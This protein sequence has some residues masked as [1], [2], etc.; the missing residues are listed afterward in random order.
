MFFQV[1]IKIYFRTL[2]NISLRIILQI[3]LDENVFENIV[4]SVRERRWRV[5]TIAS[6]R[7]CH[8]IKHAK[9]EFSVLE[10]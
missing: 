5:N 3:L 1:L 6:V 2:R 7:Y 4:V 8:T 10:Q 9:A